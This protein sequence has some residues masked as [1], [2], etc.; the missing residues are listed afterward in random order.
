MS[1]AKGTNISISMHG[2]GLQEVC[3]FIAIAKTKSHSE[4]LRELILTAIFTFPDE[5]IS[6]IE[7]VEKLLKTMFS[8]K[9]PNHLIRELLDQLISEGQIQQPLGI[10][11]VLSVEA[12]SKIKARVDDAFRLQKRVKNQWLE[13]IARQF[14]DLNTDLAWSGLYEYLANAFLQHGMQ[15]ALFLDPSVELPTVY[16]ASLSALLN[17]VVQNKFDSTHQENAKN[18]ISDFFGTIANNPERAKFVAECADGAGN[19]Y[20]LAVSTEIAGRFRDKLNPLILFCDTNVLFGILDLH[21][22]PLADVSNELVDAIAKHKIPIKLRYHENT[23]AELCSSIDHHGEILRQNKW[24]RAISRAATKSRLI[25]GLE[26]KYHQKN[27]ETALEVD[28]FLQPFKHVDALLNE[29]KLVIY[30]SEERLKERATLEADYKKFLKRINR[31][32]DHYLVAHDVIVLDCVHLLKRN[33]TSTLDSGALFVTCD[34]LLYRFDSEISRKKKTHASVV[35]PNVLLQILRPFIPSSQNFNTS[36]AETFAIP[37]F[38]TIGSGA[39]KACLKMLSLLNAYKDM[40]EDVAVRMLTND[41]LIDNLR[42]IENNKTFQAE[43]DSA[44]AADYQNLIEEVAE[45]TKEK[46]QANKKFEEQVQ[47]SELEAAKAQKA[48]ES[49]RET[50]ETT[51]KLSEEFTDLRKKNLLQ[52]KIFST[53]G[54]ILVNIILFLFIHNIWRWDWLLNHPESYGL[55]VA[56]HITVLFGIVGFF[57]NSWRKVVWSITFLGAVVIGVMQMLG[58]PEN[59]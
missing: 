18:A 24:T 38:R 2:H 23:L 45:V 11:Y 16:G 58:G 44:I 35:M 41:M 54:A 29:R 59:Q 30:R 27:S 1:K 43:V 53:I 42:G 25:S 26:K 6:N 55:Q 20:S 56:I 49:E 21:V 9:D 32:K 19:F 47:L 57:V 48:L 36:F 31:E 10:N 37:E 22:H 3:N 40:T 50:Q 13:E 12:R 46:E 39:D 7:E 52:K 14:P 4:T 34:H 28:E 17:Q 51:K 33:A 5:K 15:V 8:I